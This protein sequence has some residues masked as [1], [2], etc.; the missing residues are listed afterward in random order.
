M[1][2]EV[3]EFNEQIATRVPPGDSWRLVIEGNNGPVHKSL[4]DALQVYFEKTGFKGEYR[5]AP[6]KG[7]LYCIKETEVEI[8]VE[9]PKVYSFYGEFKQGV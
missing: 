1:N 5:L 9:Q 4:T 3:K 6:L 2:T 7:V 8:P